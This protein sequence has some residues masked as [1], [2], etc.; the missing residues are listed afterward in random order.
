MLIPFL[1]RQHKVWKHCN[2]RIFTVAQLEDNSLQMK[3]DLHTFIYQLRIKAEVDV[4]E[5]PDSDISAYTYERTLR[6]EERN[7][8]LSAM[9]LS[10]RQKRGDIQHV[11]SS[12]H[13]GSVGMNPSHSGLRW[14]RSMSESSDDKTE[15]DEPQTPVIPQ[16][17]TISEATL[18]RFTAATSSIMEPPTSNLDAHAENIRRMNTSVKLNELIAN[19]SQDA[20]LVLLNLPAPPRHL[21]H[22][23]NYMEFLDVLTEG[24]DRVLMVRGGG[25]EVITIY[26]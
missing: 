13:P 6:M 5:M 25:R 2:L 24:L 9:R 1:L 10:K 15:G 7:Q 3:R 11:L 22:E 16:T 18:S 14:Q 21:K 20:R 23:D 8:M 12:H 19:K 26:S 4:I 17:P